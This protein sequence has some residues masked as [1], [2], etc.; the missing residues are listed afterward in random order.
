M[1]VVK[2]IE[3]V[4][5]SPKSWEDAANQALARA[6]ESVENITG[7]EIK[8]MTAVVRD[9]RI[10]EYKTNLDVAFEVK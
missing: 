3:L 6:E 5:D 10:V 1:S 4:G 2:I 7:V 9:G 8:R